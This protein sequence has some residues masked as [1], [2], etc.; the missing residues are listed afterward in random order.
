[1]DDMT[2]EKWQ[3]PGDPG[4]K[5]LKLSGSVTIGEAAAFKEALL[6]ELETANELRVD[7]SAIT[8][9][10]LTGLQLLDACHGSA[11]AR[12]K[13]F[14]IDAGGNRAFLDTVAS[15]GFGRH[16]GCARDGD[17]SC[18]WVGGEY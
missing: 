6:A 3:D 5:G 15:A 8:E 13:R 4:R 17:C 12:G 11:L 16:T 7:L 10:D 18:I 9:I 14:G 2:I 1:M